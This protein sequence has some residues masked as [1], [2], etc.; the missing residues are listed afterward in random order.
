MR[1]LALPGDF[2]AIQQEVERQ[3]TILLEKLK[4]NETSE[5]TGEPRVLII[6]LTS[7]LLALIQMRR[8]AKLEAHRWR[9]AKLR[10]HD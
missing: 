10:Q 9:R 5:V 1:A 2:E 6:D 4:K 8:E 7:S 3:K